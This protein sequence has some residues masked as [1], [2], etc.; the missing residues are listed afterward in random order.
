MYRRLGHG[1]QAGWILTTTVAAS[2][3]RA[4]RREGE[5]LAAAALARIRKSWG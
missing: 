3:V 1:E 5:L 2:I 4:L